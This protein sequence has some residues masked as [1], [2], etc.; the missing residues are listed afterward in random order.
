[1]FEV[2]IVP[3]HINFNYRALFAD[4][5]GRDIPGKNKINIYPFPLKIFNVNQKYNDRLKR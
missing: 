5:I 2:I 4:P 3:L 1:L